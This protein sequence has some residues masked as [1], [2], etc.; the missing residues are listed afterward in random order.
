VRPRCVLFGTA[1]IL[2]S[3]F[4]EQGCLVNRDAGLIEDDNDGPPPCRHF[5]RLKKAN[6]PEVVNNS[7]NSLNHEDYGPFS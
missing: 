1:P 5:H 4:S 6:V 2:Q 7:L 3:C